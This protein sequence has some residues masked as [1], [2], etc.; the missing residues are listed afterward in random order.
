MSN[1]VDLLHILHVLKLFGKIGTELVLCNDNG[2]VDDVTRSTQN[3][4]LD[5]LFLIDHHQHK[6]T[7][8]LSPKTHNTKRTKRKY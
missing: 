6:D 2:A 5:V 7:T 8:F 4:F 3:L 1:L